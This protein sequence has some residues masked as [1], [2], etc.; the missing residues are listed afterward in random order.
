MK[1]ICGYAAVFDV[2]TYSVGNF[3]EKIAKNAF[4]KSIKRD[5]I[6]ALFN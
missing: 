2:E 3:A 4:A 5:D 6:R 1:R